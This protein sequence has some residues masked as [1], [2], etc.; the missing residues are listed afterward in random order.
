MSKNNIEQVTDQRFFVMVYKDFLYSKRLDF[1]EKG[2]FVYLKAHCDK[3]SGMAFPS[4]NTLQKE[5]GLSRSKI[6]K[7]LASLE[8]KGIIKVKHRITEE[9]GYRSNIY[10]LYDNQNIWKAE[11]IE[12]LKAA[13]SEIE[14]KRMIDILIAKGYNISKE[15]EPGATAP[16]KATVEPS[17]KNN[18]YS[19]INNTAQTEKSQDLERYTINQIHQLF[20]YDI[21]LSDNPYQKQD[22][23]SVINILHTAMNTRKPVIRIAGEDKPA[24]TVIATVNA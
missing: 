15:K 5:T 9:H 14:E 21:M 18:Q 1:Y 17:T 6:Q 13:V 8:E 19:G 24:M 12:E 11:N 20:D 16:T 4:L 23:D 7:C 10:T 2:I 22:I 3:E